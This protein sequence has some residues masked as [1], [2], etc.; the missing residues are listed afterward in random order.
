MTIIVR[1]KFARR[2]I[3]GINGIDCDFT[4]SAKR[5]EEE[6]S[7][8]LIREQ[9]LFAFVIE[10]IKQVKTLSF[11]VERMLAYLLDENVVRAKI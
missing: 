5:F 2:I 1:E 9:K 10:S 7:N 3:H 11:I 6:K 4:N 8:F